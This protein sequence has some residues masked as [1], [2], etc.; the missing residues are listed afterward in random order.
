L[1]SAAVCLFACAVVAAC[2]VILLVVFGSGGG[3]AL[4]PT[5]FD[6]VIAIAAT[7]PLKK[8][9]LFLFF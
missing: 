5:R 7:K 9:G 6:Q 8:T 3:C 1:R 4:Q 2:C